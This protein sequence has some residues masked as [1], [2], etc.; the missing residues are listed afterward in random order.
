MGETTSKTASFKKRELQSEA[1]RSRLEGD[2]HAAEKSLKGLL[3][4]CCETIGAADVEA[5]HEKLLNDPAAETDVRLE[6]AFLLDALGNVL[7]GIEQ[8]DR[9]A[10]ATTAPARAV[11]VAEAVAES[12][13]DGAH[14]VTTSS[15]EALR[16]IEQGLALRK[17]VQRA[18]PENE[19]LKITLARSYS[20]LAMFYHGRRMQQEA[21][22]AHLEALNLFADVPL[23][24]TARSE[25][26]PSP[27][28]SASNAS[29]LGPLPPNA[30]SMAAE[31]DLETP[32]AGNVA[33]ALEDAIKYEIPWEKFRKQRLKALQAK[34]KAHILRAHQSVQD[35]REANGGDEEDA[36]HARQDPAFASVAHGVQRVVAQAQRSR[37]VPASSGDLATSARSQRNKI[38]GTSADNRDAGQTR[39]R[40]VLLRR[41]ARVSR[42]E[43]GGGLGLI[44]PLLM[45]G[46]GELAS[47]AAEKATGL[48]TSDEHIPEVVDLDPEAQELIHLGRQSYTDALGFFQ[49]RLETTRRR[50]GFVRLDSIQHDRLISRRH[51]Q[52]K[53][54]KVHRLLATVLDNSLH[55]NKSDEN[56][57]GNEENQAVNGK[58]DAANDDKRASAPG[59]GRPA[60]EGV[61]NPETASLQTGTNAA[62][63]QD[64]ASRAAAGRPNNGEAVAAAAPSS[65]SSSSLSA[66]P[67]PSDPAAEAAAAAQ[68]RSHQN[69]DELAWVIRDLDSTNGI[70]VNGIRVQEYPLR[71]G[72]IVSFGGATSVPFGCAVLTHKRRPVSSVFVYRFEVV[73]AGTRAEAKRPEWKQ[74]GS[75]TADWMP[76]LSTVSSQLDPLVE[77]FMQEKARSRDENE[78][79]SSDMESFHFFVLYI[80]AHP[81]YIPQDD[82]QI[83]TQLVESVHAAN[84]LHRKAVELDIPFSHWASWIRAQALSRPL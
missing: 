2:L 57:A 1:L 62:S 23:H 39:C 11:D 40:L 19:R 32:D 28:G 30:S 65:S 12:K 29:T 21:D 7:R 42:A 71:D 64:D 26:P 80:C 22:K 35:K 70:L 10:A 54:S 60:E 8:E 73:K 75:M 36:G 4:V 41:D 50:I 25:K 43:T 72:D 78:P 52:L 49:S 81:E 38:G 84:L 53:F 16:R 6:V 9:V 61:K 37:N 66:P 13:N 79:A 59:A 3:D 46:E 51:A 82:A 5:V 15:S 69:A 27:A 74:Y 58:S 47:R 67:S 20:S 55:E 56:N 14:E 33:A 76:A 44:N 68:E 48:D 24:S 77:V 18:D 45:T 34:V 83:R 63:G 17:A 31:D